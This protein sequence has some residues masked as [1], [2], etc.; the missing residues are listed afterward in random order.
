MNPRKSP[1]T[2]ETPTFTVSVNNTPRS[3]STTLNLQQA[4]QHWGHDADS[5][6]G[7]ARNQVFVPRQYWCSTWLEPG[8]RI[9]I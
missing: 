1:V 5:L 9:D 7:I 3:V 8:D 4:L 2:P 6:L